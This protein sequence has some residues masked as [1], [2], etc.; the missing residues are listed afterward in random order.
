MDAQ[1]R[2]ERA[3]KEEQD[4]KVRAKAE[5]LKAKSDAAAAAA[6]A[7]TPAVKSTPPA[8]VR[9]VPTIRLP[10][11]KK[12]APTVTIPKAE[13]AA[14]ATSAEDAPSPKSR[15]TFSLFGFG[16][17]AASESN[18]E[19]SATTATA[20]TAKT[21]PSPVI[22]KAA[23][24]APKATAPRGVPT[25]SKWKFDASDNTISGLISGSNAFK[26]GEPVTTSAIV[27]EAASNSVVR[28]KSGS[29][30][31][32]GEEDAS[33]S[34]GGGGGGGVFGLF[35]SGGDSG[36]STEVKAVA[37]S[38]PDAGASARKK[39]EEDRQRAADEA[40]AAQAEARKQAA[41]EAKAKQEA[42]I[43]AR[44]Q[45]EEDRKRAADEAKAKKEA[46]IAARK[47]AD[48]D[49]K[50]AAQEFAEQRAAEAE[51]RKQKEL[52]RKRQQQA[53]ATGKKAS[54]VVVPPR[55]KQQQQKQQ[56]I[57][58]KK[59]APAPSA[60]RPTFSL[61]GF[62]GS[63]TSEPKEE[64]PAATAVVASTPPTRNAPSAPRGV[65][66]IAKWKFDPSDNTISGFISGSSAFKDGEPVT[67]SAI[68]GDAIANSV[69]RTKSGSRYVFFLF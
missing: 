58:A 20:A 55:R 53:A 26:N 56:Q 7:A 3:R 42:A 44:T 45:A 59:E 64:T 37:P 19:S 17:G 69:V 30:Y 28:T 43:A 60:P 22:N 54:R 48:E 29:R 16:G 5:A 33:P 57:P 31:F 62:G 35:G 38:Q 49:R 61:F 34:R 14:A 15:P 63:A 39:A 23:A 24:S 51:A 32:L 67:T 21:S 50:R 13:K 40:K 41:E 1:Q 27:G 47:Q 6:A 8:P 18:D 66:T 10:Q 65:P 9:R 12:K 2:E 36:S 11:P 52:E 25:I 46:E 4:A 68:V